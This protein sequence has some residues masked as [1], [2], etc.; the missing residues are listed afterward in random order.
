MG[1]VLGPGRKVL[2]EKSHTLEQHSSMFTRALIRFAFFA[3]LS[4][5]AMPAGA[6]AF[7][8]NGQ[9]ALVVASRPSVADARAYIL[10]NGWANLGIRIHE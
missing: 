3:T 9:C 10:E 6:A 4:S 1:V 7:F 5:A 8:P 2:V